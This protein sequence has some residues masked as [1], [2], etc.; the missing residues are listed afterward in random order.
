MF[1][2]FASPDRKMRANAVKW[3]ELADKVHHYRRDQIT[4][5]ELADLET[6]TQELRRLVRDRAERMKVKI[7]VDSLEGVLRQLGGHHYPKSSLVEN[8]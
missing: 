5:A 1:G 4:A 2:I 7:A 8:V 6:N 3:L